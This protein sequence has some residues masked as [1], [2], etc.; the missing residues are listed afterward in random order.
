MGFINKIK[1]YLPSH[2][3]QKNLS[4]TINENHINIKSEIENLNYKIEFLFWN[5][6]KRE[7]ETTLDTRKRVFLNMPKA[8]GDIRKI[9][10]GS[11][12]ILKKLDEICSKNNIKYFIQDGTLLGAVRHEGFIPW[13]DDI[14][15]GMMRAEYDK[16]RDVLE[17]DDL[18]DIGYYYNI[19]GQTII[20][21]KFVF[22]ELFYIDIFLW[23]YFDSSNSNFIKRIKQIRQE[24][25]LFND[26]MKN[27]ISKHFKADNSLIISKKIPELDNFLFQYEKNIF[28]KLDFYGKG[29]YICG[30]FYNSL[31]FWDTM[32]PQNINDCFPLVQKFKFEGMSFNSFKNYIKVLEKQYG[33][34]YEFPYNLKGHMDRKLDI[35]KE[36]E[37]LINRNLVADGE[38]I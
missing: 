34:Y 24:S 10:I 1:K 22:S 28:K 32:L 16:L 20:K 14:D 36:F 35:D 33:N 27:K 7:N 31:C 15:I 37:K 19:F 21:V 8:V 4:S 6:Q 38:V 18:L 3:I 12:A 9:Q 30:S 2:R 23:D 25:V 29:K 17:H 5:L 26:I 13:D 11:F